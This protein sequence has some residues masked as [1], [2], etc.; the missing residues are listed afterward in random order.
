VKPDFDFT[1]ESVLKPAAQRRVATWLLQT[2]QVLCDEQLLRL[3]L[4]PDPFPH[5]DAQIHTNVKNDA[6][7]RTV[8]FRAL[9]P[10]TLAQLGSSLAHLAGT[11]EVGLM[12]AADPAHWV[13]LPGAARKIPDARYASP[14]GL[15]LVEYDACGYTASV[16][17]DK[18]QAF[19]AEGQVLWATSSG[20]R[21]ET[22]ALRH[23]G[24][25]VHYVPWWETRE[26]RAHT[27]S[28]GDG[29]LGA[30]RRRQYLLSPR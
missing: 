10:Q 16:V 4:N 7:S 12:L 6:T 8:R 5:R 18:V 23:R 17:R 27:R 19:R 22:I 28:G 15:V 14:D 24:V 1:G 20:L 13:V 29:T 2:H 30:A 9:K 11:A 25:K 3:G 21:A 26:E